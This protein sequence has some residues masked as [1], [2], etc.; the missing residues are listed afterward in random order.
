MIWLV[1]PFFALHILERFA[2]L[3][4]SGEQCPSSMILTW[5]PFYSICRSSSWQV[6]FKDV[7]N[8]EQENRE[9]TLL[10]IGFLTRRKAI[11]PTSTFLVIPYCVI[12]SEQ[13]CCCKLLTRQGSTENVNS[14]EI[15]QLPRF[16]LKTSIEFNI[17]TALCPQLKEST[18]IM[19]INWHVIYILHSF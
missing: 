4:I 9:E 2:L 8:I 15:K 13:F 18:A 5:K 6:V 12:V 16:T 11:F 7:E 14:V 19:T 3:L 17:N 1:T 10:K